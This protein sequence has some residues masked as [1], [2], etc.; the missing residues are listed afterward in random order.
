MLFPGNSSDNLNHYYQSFTKW[1]KVY[2]RNIKLVNWIINLR[3][4]GEGVGLIKH[5]V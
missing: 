3:K 4:G 2:D 5:I 1:F